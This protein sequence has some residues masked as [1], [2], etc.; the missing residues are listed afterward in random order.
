PWDDLTAVV[1][2]AGLKPADVAIQRNLEY[3]RFGNLLLAITPFNERGDW[4][5]RRRSFAAADTYRGDPFALTPTTITERH[6]AS[7]PAGPSPVG[8]A[9]AYGRAAADF[10]KITEYASRTEVD[11]HHG[12]PKL[13]ADINQNKIY[14]NEDNWGRVRTVATDWG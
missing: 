4:I 9:C 6:C 12:A 11:E 1:A 2:S 8:G 7:E 3:D 5:E 14:Y 10:K 13:S